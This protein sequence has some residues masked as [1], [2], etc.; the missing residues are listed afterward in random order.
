MKTIE[1]AVPVIRMK[2]KQPAAIKDGISDNQKGIHG[3]DIVLN[4]SFRDAMIRFG[5]TLLLPM[6]VLVI[7]KG[8]IIYTAPVM[9]YTFAS[10]ITHF[11]VIK[12]IWRR[13]IKHERRPMAMEYG[14]DPDYPEESL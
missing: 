6:L 9:A 13:Y 4:V 5:I 1:T 14:K 10:A 11:C 7:D 2:F 3:N 8:L 12:S